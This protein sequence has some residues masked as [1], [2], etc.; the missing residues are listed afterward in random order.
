MR[1]QPND[2]RLTLLPLHHPPTLTLLLLDYLKSLARHPV[3]PIQADLVLER[4][5]LEVSENPLS[6][7]DHCALGPDTLNS[8]WDGGMSES[9]D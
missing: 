2:P 6:S 3:K 8:K 9:A 5:F 7:C 4:H 1:L